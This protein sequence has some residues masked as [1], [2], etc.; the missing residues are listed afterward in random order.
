MKRTT[1]IALLALG[2]GSVAFYATYEPGECR[3]AN[4]AEAQVPLLEQLSGEEL[5]TQLASRAERELPPCGAS[6]SRGGSTS[7]SRSSRRW[8]GSSTSSPSSSV[9]TS[10][11]SSQQAF[12]SRGG[13]GGSGAA[14]AGGG[15]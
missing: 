7:H 15:A 13:F 11:A 8:F 6:R 2:T 3:P 14:H 5:K 9:S 10:A 1:T 12:L 4:G